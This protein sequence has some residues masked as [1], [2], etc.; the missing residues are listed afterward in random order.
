MRDSGHLPTRGRCPRCGYSVRLKTDG[1][2]QRHRVYVGA[3]WTYCHETPWLDV[4]GPAVVRVDLD[5]DKGTV[6]YG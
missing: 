4:I 3:E 1:R 2:P 5:F 6:T